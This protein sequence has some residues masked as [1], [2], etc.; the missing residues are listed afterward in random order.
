MPRAVNCD[1]RIL[2]KMEGEGTEN[3]KEGDEGEK[4]MVEESQGK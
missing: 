2:K 3:N 1:V 4:V